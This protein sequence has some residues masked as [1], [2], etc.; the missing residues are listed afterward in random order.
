MRTIVMGNG[1]TKSLQTPLSFDAYVTFTDS[2]PGN[3][4]AQP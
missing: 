4:R 2:N 1:S 3:A